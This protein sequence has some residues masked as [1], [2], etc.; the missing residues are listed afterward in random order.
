MPSS[1]AILAVV[2]YLLEDRMTPLVPDIIL[3]LILAA[4]KSPLVDSAILI[5]FNSG[6]ENVLAREHHKPSIRIPPSALCGFT[7]SDWGGKFFAILGERCLFSR[8]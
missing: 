4:K 6:G 7:E 1:M 3:L 5:V 8:E 2:I